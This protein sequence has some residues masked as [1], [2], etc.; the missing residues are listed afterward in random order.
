MCSGAFNHSFTDPDVL[1]VN[2]TKV[3][4]SSSV[5]LQWDEA[6]DTDYIVTWGSDGSAFTQSRT[7]RDESSY[8]ITGLTLDTVYNITVTATNTCGVGPEYRAS[9]SL[10][11]M[12][13]VTPSIASVTVATY[14]TTTTATTNI[15]NIFASTTQCYNPAV[16]TS[17][18]SNNK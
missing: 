7:L 11:A 13:S 17:K 12:I 2:I 15:T 9:V 6:D 18:C 14:T 16:T 8:T 10:A 4:G 1:S 3:N 5:V